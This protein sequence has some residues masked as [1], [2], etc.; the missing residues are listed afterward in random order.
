MNPD[1]GQ[2]AIV[3]EAMSAAK[4]MVEES[5]DELNKKVKQA[6]DTIEKFATEQEAKAAGF[7]ESISSEEM[8]KL[9]PLSREKRIAYINHRRKVKENNVAKRR[10]KAKAARLARRI[11]RPKK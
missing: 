11:N 4:D 2:L 10:A 8:D 5:T 9:I 7:T 6:A 3:E 1:T